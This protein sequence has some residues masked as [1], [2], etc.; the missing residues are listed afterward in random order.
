MSISLCIWSGAMSSIAPAMPKPALHIITSSRP[1]RST[2]RA[3]KASISSARVTSA[4]IAS[5]SPPPAAISA[6]T[7]ASRS[8]RR[9]QIATAAPG[10]A[11]R[12]AVARPIPADA[13][14]IAITRIASAY[15]E[16]YPNHEDTKTTKHARRKPSSI[17]FVSP[18]VTFATSG[19][20]QGQG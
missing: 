6:A 2:V 19:L 4:A 17:F 5:A 1:K 18:F 14:V 11:S 15:R 10:R 13:P 16:R 9:A 12:S 20:G 7:A 8:A 3:T